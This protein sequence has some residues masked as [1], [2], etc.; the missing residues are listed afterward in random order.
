MESDSLSEIYLGRYL[1]FDLCL[2]DSSEVPPMPS[3]LP[4]Y[5]YFMYVDGPNIT[6]WFT[7]LPG[8]N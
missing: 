8:R 4:E 5:S 7:S 3:E 1:V 6:S 2:D